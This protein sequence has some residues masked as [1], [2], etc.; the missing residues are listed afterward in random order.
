MLFLRLCFLKIFCFL[1]LFFLSFGMQ[2]TTKQQD[3]FLFHGYEWRKA[4]IIGQG[5]IQ[6]WR[7][8]IKSCP[9][10]TRS[11]I[12]SEELQYPF[13]TEHNHH[14]NPDSNIVR[15]RKEQI[16]EQAREQPESAPRTLIGAAREQLTDNQ[17]VH[18][19]SYR[20]SQAAIGRQ[21]QI[22]DRAEVNAALPLEIEINVHN[23]YR[24]LLNYNNNRVHLP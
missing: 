18:M 14:P 21:R 19:P 7:C 13:Q 23:N 16:K 11:A 17:L 2:K 10:R 1:S 24:F 8:P 20:A 15:Q 22:P 5:Q 4:D 3:L 6:V 9:G 12:N